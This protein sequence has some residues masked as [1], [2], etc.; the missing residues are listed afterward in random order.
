MCNANCPPCHKWTDFVEK[1]S[2]KI[3]DFTKNKCI[4]VK[5][6]ILDKGLS[7]WTV[8]KACELKHGRERARWTEGPIFFILYVLTPG[9]YYYVMVV[10]LCLAKEIVV[11]MHGWSIVIFFCE[12]TSVSLWYSSIPWI[13]SK[14]TTVDMP[15]LPGKSMF[16][17]PAI[18]KLWQR[19]K[20]LGNLSKTP[21]MGTRSFQSMLKKTVSSL[22]VAQ[23]ITSLPRRS[24]EGL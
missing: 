15:E 6:D 3:V 7:E 20:E 10:S 21:A 13:F 4:T 1:R 24:Q 8:L 9:H 11:V 19:L 2:A 23:I 18:A 12:A 22:P 17:H 14:F 5:L 16:R